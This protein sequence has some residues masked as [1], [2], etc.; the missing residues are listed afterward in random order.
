MS[1]KAPWITYRPELKV[2]DCTIRDG[3]LINNHQFTDEVVR[4]VYDTCIQAGIDYM[5]IGYKNSPR[6]FPKS[7]FG[8]WRHC[9][10]DDLNR[11]VGGHDAEKTGLKLAAMADAEKSDWKVQVV[12]RS[13]SV[14]DLIRVA[15][16]AHQVSEAVEMINHFHD[17]GYETMANLMAVSNIT[18]TEIDTVLESIAPTPAGTMVIVDSFGHLYREQIDRLYKKYA[19][20]M[21][22]T[23]KEIGIHAHNNMQLAFANTIEAII[24]GS[25]RVDATMLGLGR[26]AGNCPMEILLGFLRNPKFSLRPVIK[27]LQDHIIPLRDTV[28]WG[29]LI[30]FNITGQLNLHPQHA[31]KYR[32]SETKD[33]FVKF[34]DELKS[35][36]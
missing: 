1:E 14:L 20:A 5:E 16:Y 17:L 32:K 36:I 28:E 19:A 26:G 35:E 13:E 23:G 10:E 15:F 31:I 8:A 29:P 2:L 33:D 30:P 22:G 6:L 12:P 27:L 3:G 9:D 25:N 34:Y 21:E 11:V 4:A 7:E 24:L 18:E